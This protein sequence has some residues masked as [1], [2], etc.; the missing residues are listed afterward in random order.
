MAKQAKAFEIE[1][2]LADG[3]E[4]VTPADTE[5]KGTNA[6][7]RWIRDNGEPGETYRVVQICTAPMTVME[8]SRP[9]RSLKP[10][11]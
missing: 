5:L 7:R 6:A 1:L 8:E 2:A 3:W 9:V 10:V 4:S 11:E